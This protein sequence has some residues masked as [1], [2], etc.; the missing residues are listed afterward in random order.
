MRAREYAY[1]ALVYSGPCT[2]LGRVAWVDTPMNRILGDQACR[3][4]ISTTFCSSIARVIGP[5]PPGFGVYAEA[6][7]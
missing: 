1:I 4:A 6:F 5:T 7:S 2:K 3:S